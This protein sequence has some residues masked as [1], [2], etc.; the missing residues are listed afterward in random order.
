M[1]NIKRNYNFLRLL[2]SATSPQKK[3][4]IRTASKNQIYSLCEICKNILAGN[5]PVNIK[6]LC[7]YKT[8]IRQMSNKKV[9][10]NKKRKLLANQ[11]GGFL[12][13]VLAPVL[14]ALGGII[15]KAIGN[16]I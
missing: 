2:A 5:V 4:I 1:K 9:S 14:S 13:L 7:K 12:P 3:A 15:G 10:I 6:R 11:S 16:R 8:A